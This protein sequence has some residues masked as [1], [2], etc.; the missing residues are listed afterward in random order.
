MANDHTTQPDALTRTLAYGVYNT[1]DHFRSIP[2]HSCVCF[3]DDLGLVAVTGPAGDP[4]SER[5]AEFFAAAPALLVASA[6]LVAALDTINVADESGEMGTLDWDEIKKMNAER[7]D[8]HEALRLAI[9]EAR[10]EKLP[11]NE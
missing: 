1:T 5:Y 2:Q 6:R 3:T 10:G 9:A 7:D 4:Q 11:T 8:A